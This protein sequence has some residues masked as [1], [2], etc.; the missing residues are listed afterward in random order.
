MENRPGYPGRFFGF[1]SQP[2]QEECRQ[3]QIW[4]GEYM[5]YI[6]SRQARQFIL[7]KQGLLGGYRFSGKQG[8][9]DYVRQAGCIQF[10]PV[11]ACGKNAELTLQSRVKGFTKQMLYD[12]LYTD[13]ALVDYPDK[14]LAIFPVEDWPYFAR[15]RNMAR[16]NAAQFPDLPELEAQA[17]AYIRENG[18]VCSDELPVEGEIHWHSSIHWSGNWH[19]KSNA[20]RSVLEQLYSTGELVIHHKNGT[21]K[22]YDLAQRHIPP[23]I[24]QAPDPLA[25]DFAHLQWRILRRIGAVGLLWDRPSDAWLNI[26]GLTT[27]QRHEAIMQL[28]AQGSLLPVQVEGIRQT[29]YCCAQDE[30]LMRAVLGAEKAFQPRCSFIAPLDPF[31]WDRKLIRALF[32]FDYG[33]EIYTP[34]EKRKFGYYVLPVV[35]GERFVGRMEAVAQAKTGLLEVRNI[36]YE[37]GV[38]QTKKLVSEI[39]RAVKRLAK[40]NG[41]RE[42]VWMCGEK[43]DSSTD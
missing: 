28:Q 26:W 18:P 12:L 30:G 31:M 6:S 38:R 15:Y 20:A 27:Q 3:N 37:D 13:R 1:E 22:F 25:D 5:L 10:D 23:S 29:L 2:D 35:Y 14:Q 8:V 36:W 39:G 24:L 7:L 21:R 19:G 41:C 16:E 42:I 40:F 9:L 32:S 33:W 34:A 11:D 4:K 17:K 43:N